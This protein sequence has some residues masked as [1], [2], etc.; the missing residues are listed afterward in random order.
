MTGTPTPSAFP[1][2]GLTSRSLDAY[3]RAIGLLRTA[4]EI[5]LD[6]RAHWDASGVLSINTDPETV[7]DALVA[8]VH[9]QP[10]AIFPPVRTPWRGK[11]AEGDFPSLRA[12][13]S[14]DELAWFDACY[15]AV[16]DEHQVFPRVNPLLGKGGSFGR[17]EIGPAY[18]DAL[19]RL[20]GDKAAGSLAPGLWATLLAEPID[21]KLLRPLLVKKKAL[22]AYQSGRGTGPGASRNDAQPTNQEAPV[23]AWDLV[24]LVAGLVC[25]SGLATI[26]PSGS[27]RTASFPWVVSPRPVGFDA[28]R[29]E[30]DQGQQQFEFLAPLWSAPATPRVILH[31]IARV[32]LRNR[33]RA[34]ADT[35]EAL[36]AHADQGAAEFGFDRL[37]RFAFVAPSDPRYQYAV[38]RGSSYALRA[39]QAALIARDILPYLRTGRPGD[40]APA[41]WRRAH[42][43]A[44]ELAVRAAQPRAASPADRPPRV[45]WRA[46]ELLAH[47]E[48]LDRALARGRGA[49]RLRRTGGEWWRVLRQRDDEPA[50]RTSAS[51]AAGLAW[52]ASHPDGPPWSVGR[53]ALLPH[54]RAKSSRGWELD[55]D[56]SAPPLLI[57]DRPLPHLARALV[58]AHRKLSAEDDLRVDSAPPRLADLVRLLAGELAGRDV[59]VATLA[60]ARIDDPPRPGGEPVQVPAELG[61]S[62]AAVLYAP[63]AGA[64]T[65]G[66][67]PGAGEVTVR[68]VVLAEL[69]LGGRT[70][71][72][73]RAAGRHLARADLDPA[74]S[75]GAGLGSL[76]P[77]RLALA[78]L[79]GLRKSD[80]HGLHE[81]LARFGSGTASEEPEEEIN[82]NGD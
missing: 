79:A 40:N 37:E 39:P 53:A 68:R 28:A 27:S 21:A 25:F 1:L 46:V 22:G 81:R 29:T 7:V 32:R 57:E 24:L 3:L 58:A 19:D 64:G 10:D 80:R 82:D 11:D 33:T 78:L 6:L 47:L 52:A 45:G 66:E 48:P 56:A 60:A 65:D 49:T 35:T 61:L 67:T 13:A 54:R 26:R 2:P 51:I 69:A 14:G 62:L 70:L 34:V 38:R 42:R 12:R 5:D 72:L 59:A 73:A 16:A 71:D 63:Y 23:N 55:P 4:Q 41:T 44:E 17:A 15:V 36:V 8:A 30:L 20:R 9:R 43:D 18:E 76:A 75:A 74:L 31:R 77:E 50:H